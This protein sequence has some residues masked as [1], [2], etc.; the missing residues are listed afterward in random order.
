[1]ELGG[2]TAREQRAGGG[3]ARGQRLGAEVAGVQP[4]DAWKESRREKRRK[5]K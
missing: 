3:V 1:M 4:R 5:T 2:D